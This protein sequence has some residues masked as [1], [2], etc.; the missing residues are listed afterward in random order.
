MTRLV[1]WDVDTLYDFM[2]A[3]GR[4]HL[5]ASEEIIVLNTRWRDCCVTGRRRTCSSSPDAIR[6]IY[7]DQAERLLQSWRDRGVHFMLAS[8]VLA[9][10]GLEPYLHPGV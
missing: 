3:D 1:L 10:R 7:P 9:G 4:L 8:D 2:H 5:P 6:A